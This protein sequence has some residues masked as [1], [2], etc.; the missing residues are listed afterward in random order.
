MSKKIT[1]ING[2]VVL[3]PVEEAEQTF[4]NIVIPD[5]GKERPEMGKVVE[6][7][8]TYNYHTDNEVESCL[9]PG[10]IVLIPKLGS[11][12]IVIEGEDYYICK[13][14]DILAIID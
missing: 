8:S 6:S 13:E 2:Y 7:S 14:T 9:K 10:D 4:G 12:R 3:K 1:P 5:L 11:Q